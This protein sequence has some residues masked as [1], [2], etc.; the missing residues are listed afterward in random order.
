[1]LFFNEEQTEQ[2]FQDLN[3][4]IKNTFVDFIDIFGDLVITDIRLFE[5]QSVI[6]SDFRYKETTFTLYFDFN[7]FGAGLKIEIFNLIESISGETFD[8]LL[9]HIIRNFDVPTRL[10]H[11]SY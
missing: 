9:I 4:N 2:M 5:S 3:P 11:G 6:T 7:Q 1:M 8:E 10:T